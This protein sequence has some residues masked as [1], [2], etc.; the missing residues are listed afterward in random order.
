MAINIEDYTDANGRVNYGR[1]NADLKKLREDNYKRAYFTFSEAQQLARSNGGYL[2]KPTEEHF[3][4][5]I[6]G[7]IYHLYPRTQ[8]IAIDPHCPGPFLEVGKPWTFLDVVATA[9]IVTQIPPQ[10]LLK[11]AGIER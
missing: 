11:D 2:F 10:K 6:G 4:L 7:F 9:I 1:F 3:K 8:G 5:K